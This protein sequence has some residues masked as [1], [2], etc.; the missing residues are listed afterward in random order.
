M[1]SSVAR[2]IE[3]VLS[4]REKDGADATATQRQALEFMRDQHPGI[5]IDHIEEPSGEEASPARSRAMLMRLRSHAEARTFDELRIFEIGRLIRPEDPAWHQSIIDLVHQARAVVV[6]STGL[7]ADPANPSGVRAAP[8]GGAARPGLDQGRPAQAARTSESRAVPASA[9]RDSVQAPPQVHAPGPLHP[10]EAP[11]PRWEPRRALGL[12]SNTGQAITAGFT[13]VCEGRVFCEVCGQP[14]TIQSLG[15]ERK[16]YYACASLHLHPPSDCQPEVSFPVD[17]VDQVVWE[18]LI[19]ALDPI[20]PAIDSLRKALSRDL[21]SGEDRRAQSQVRLERLGRDELEVLGLRSDDRISESAARRRLEEISRERRAIEDQLRDGAGAAQPL[22]VLLKAIEEIL[23][24]GAQ[25]QGV[26]PADRRRLLLAAIPDSAEYGVQLQVN[27]QIRTHS[28]LDQHDLRP[29]MR[30]KARAIGA[31]VQGLKERVRD[32]EPTRPAS[33]LRSSLASLVERFRRA[34]APE[35]RSVALAAAPGELDLS[36]STGVS[37]A[38]LAAYGMALVAS[39]LIAIVLRPAR[40]DSSPSENLAEQLGMAEQLDELYRVPGGW[41]GRTA[42]TW[43]GSDDEPLAR[44]ACRALA[45]QLK[46]GQRETITL[47]RPEGVPIAECGP[48]VD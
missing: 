31:A 27:G 6:D 12:A 16:R 47:L 11:A 18:R 30:H 5:L 23:P 4:P 17:T 13:A 41:M 45:Q 32:L 46:P 29:T 20:E 42:P 40:V 7:V 44:A 25:E 38:R 1:N 8:M 22:K 21:A 2:F 39:A 43:A 34:P 9:G 3:L 36:R 14:L 33:A 15:H 24:A 35:R 48:P 10:R 37:A 19:S 26:R 28:L